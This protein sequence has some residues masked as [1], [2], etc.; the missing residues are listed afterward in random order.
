V[1]VSDRLRAARYAGQVAPVVAFGGI[2]LATLLAPWFSWP[3]DALS[4]LG[5]AATS[6][7]ALLF[8]GALVAG[9]LLALPYAGALWADAEDEDDADGGTDPG[10]L[11]ARGVAV[12]FGLSAVLMALVGVFPIPAELVLAGT[13]VEP[14]GP[15]A[16]GF[17]LGLT[18]TLA[19][20]GLR[21]LGERA[22]QASLALAAVHVGSW[23]VWAAGVR[24][25]PGLAI[26]EAV[27]AAALSVW[28]WAL[29]PSRP[30]RTAP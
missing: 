6:S 20:D 15:V 10:R 7:V 22:G 1:S 9:G 17:Y 23:L 16:V 5:V 4:D 29:S 12:L 18:A 21:R 24:P 26:P 14:H 8:N 27:G 13:V 30:R 2:L 25:G 11:A 19:V 3:G 28:V